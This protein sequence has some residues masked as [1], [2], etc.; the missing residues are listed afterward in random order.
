MLLPMRKTKSVSLLI[1]LDYLRHA[2]LARAV[3]T[4]SVPVSTFSKAFAD[5]RDIADALLNRK[6]GL[7]KGHRTEVEDLRNM[8]NDA[9]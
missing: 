5:A 6:P 8:F 4:S 3:L 9:I 2:C 7:S 1:L